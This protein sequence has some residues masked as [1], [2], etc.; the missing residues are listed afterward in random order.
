MLEHFFPHGRM[1][2]G[3]ALTQHCGVGSCFVRLNHSDSC[4]MYQLQQF[5]RSRSSWS[6]ASPVRVPNPHG[7]LPLGCPA[8][9]PPSLSVS[10]NETRDTAA[11]GCFFFYKQTT[12]KAQCNP[13]TQDHHWTYSYK[14]RTCQLSWQSFSRPWWSARCKRERDR[15]DLWLSLCSWLPHLQVPWKPHCTTRMWEGL[16]QL[17]AKENSCLLFAHAWVVA[18]YV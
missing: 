2:M 9:V 16:F 8:T 10:P 14:I 18:D 1:W 3:A 4:N 6:S 12:R 15:W 13:L 7:E 5:I 17:I 11:A